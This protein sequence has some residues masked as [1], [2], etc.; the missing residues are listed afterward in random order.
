MLKRIRLD[1]SR[2]LGEQITRRPASGETERTADDALAR[3]EK[4]LP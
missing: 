4:A 3:P 2:S 1:L